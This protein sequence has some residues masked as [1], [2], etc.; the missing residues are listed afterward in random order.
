MLI[1]VRDILVELSDENWDDP[2]NRFKVKV[3]AIGPLKHKRDRLGIC[4]DIHRETGFIRKDVY[5]VL[6]RVTSYLE[7][8]GYRK[9]GDDI[10]DGYNCCII[11][12]WRG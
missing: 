11:Y 1:W 3:R 5:S 8:E 4:I 10:F 2:T 12:R 9:L 7:S 6:D